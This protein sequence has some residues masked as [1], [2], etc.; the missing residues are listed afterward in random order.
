MFTGL[1][2]YSVMY[3][4]TT[5]MNLYGYLICFCTQRP[6][7]IIDSDSDDDDKS[8]KHESDPANIN[9]SDSDDTTEENES[10]LESCGKNRM[11]RLADTSDADTSSSDGSGLCSYLSLSA[12]Y[13]LSALSMIGY[14]VFNFLFSYSQF[15][16][17]RCAKTRLLVVQSVCLFLRCSL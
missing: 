3:V 12:V 13:L 14:L 1:I 8:E 16:W 11:H 9:D 4:F 10:K 2:L 15:L 17:R 6:A 7:N 5:I